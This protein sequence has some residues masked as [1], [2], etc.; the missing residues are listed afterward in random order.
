M[1][2]R[3]LV[4]MDGSAAAAEALRVA[5]GLAAPVDA[6]ISVLTVQKRRLNPEPGDMSTGTRSE[7]FEII[8]AMNRKRAQSVLDDASDKLT[9]GATRFDL[10]IVE[11][12]QP[13]EGILGQVA[14]SGADL[15]VMGSHGRRGI[16]RLLLGSQASKVVAL[17]PVPVLVCKAPGEQEPDQG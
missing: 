1:F 7:A 4:P 16:H 17:S 6:T 10:S 11:A 5:Q 12:D 15:I 14:T 8:D 9:G 3:I 13:Y 2:T